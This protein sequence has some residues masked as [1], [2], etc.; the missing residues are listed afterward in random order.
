MATQ[1][2]LE[3]LS[4]VVRGVLSKFASPTVDKSNVHGARGQ[5]G[6]VVWESELPIITAMLVSNMAA[7]AAVELEANDLLNEGK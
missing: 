1:R 3:E 4:G 5:V 2:K 7:F 6:Y